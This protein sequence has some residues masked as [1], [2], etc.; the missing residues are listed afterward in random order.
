MEITKMKLAAR[1]P[2][3]DYPF[4]AAVVRNELRAGTHP[5][6]SD[7]LVCIGCGL[8]S[9]LEVDSQVESRLVVRELTAE[10]LLGL[11]CSSLELMRKAT[12][13]IELIRDQTMPL[14]G[15]LGWTAE[16]LPEK[17][18]RSAI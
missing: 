13:A 14:T 5:H 1:C 18:R 9:L 6:P 7:V 12:K 10:E 3:C 8:W 16:H 11:P 15:F 4:E 2:N 17:L